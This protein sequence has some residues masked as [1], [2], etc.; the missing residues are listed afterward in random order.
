MKDNKDKIHFRYAVT[1]VWPLWN[2]KTVYRPSD[3]G[4]SELC[5]ALLMKNENSQLNV[6]PRVGPCVT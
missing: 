1:A 3:G 4:T 6:Y 5:A 2:R